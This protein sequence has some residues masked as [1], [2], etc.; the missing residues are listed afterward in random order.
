MKTTIRS[1]AVLAF[2]LA[3]FAQPTGAGAGGAT[4]NGH[5]KD[6]GTDASE[7]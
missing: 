5:F 2:L 6:L 4:N 3:A 1:V 7:M